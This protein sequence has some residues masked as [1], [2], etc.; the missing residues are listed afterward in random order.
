MSNIITLI[1]P[2]GANAPHGE[3]VIV[4]QGTTTH[5]AFTELGYVVDPPANPE[6]SRRKTLTQMNTAELEA[7]AKE[8]GLEFSEEVNTNPERVAAIKAHLEETKNG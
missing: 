5:E 6:P 1:H 3:S 4:E 2:E 8:L 7:Y